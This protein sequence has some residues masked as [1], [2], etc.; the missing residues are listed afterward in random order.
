MA[1][2]TVTDLADGTGATVAVVPDGPS[3]YRVQRA[4]VTA[5][6]V[7]AYSNVIGPTAGDIEEDVSG[8][9]YYYW[10]MVDDST[11]AVLVGPTYQPATAQGDSVY[12]RCLVMM[13]DKITGL[14]LSGLTGGVF[15]RQM[16][17]ENNLTFP[18]IL[19]SIA[20]RAETLLGGTNEQD[21]Y[22]YPVVVQIVE[23]CAATTDVNRAR[24]LMWREKIHRSIDQRR[25]DL[26]VPEVWK[27]E[28]QPAPVISIP[29]TE[30]QKD[31]R[32]GL[33]TALCVARQSRI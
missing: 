9:G 24:H 18:C 25:W 10:R 13:K 26:R 2:L 7:G 16:A 27:V 11:S 4:T 22:G 15:I 21:D 6:A 32:D 8:T 3:A 19:L 28:V 33:L 29:E 31:Y 23:R 17:E 20:G 14:S 30:A 12:E 1:T 5:S